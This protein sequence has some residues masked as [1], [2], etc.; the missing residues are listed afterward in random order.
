MG[1]QGA[2][3]GRLGLAHKPSLKELACGVVVDRGRLVQPTDSFSLALNS[4]RQA[5]AGGFAMLRGARVVYDRGE[6]IR[7]LLVSEIRRA[8][9]CHRPI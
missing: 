7:Q 4:Y 3:A 2:E 8:G 1:E 9:K 6:D 5:G